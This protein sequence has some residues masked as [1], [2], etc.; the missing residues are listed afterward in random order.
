MYLVWLGLDGSNLAV[1]IVTLD[2]M[3]RAYLTS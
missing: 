1:A 2:T 3:M